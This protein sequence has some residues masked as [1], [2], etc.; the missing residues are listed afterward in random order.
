VASVSTGLDVVTDKGTVQGSTSGGVRSFLGIPY[1]ASPEG[2][3]RWKVPQPVAAWTGT[4]DATALG[5]V[6]PQPVAWPA[7]NAWRGSDGGTDDGGSETPIVTYNEASSEDC[8]SI[9]VWTPD[10]AP[11]APL[12]VMVYIHGGA[13]FFGSSTKDFGSDS[14]APIFTGQ[15]LVPKG[16]VVVVTFNYRLGQLGFLAHNALSA[17]SASGSSGNYGLLDQRA[18]LQ[19]VQTNIAAFGGDKNNVTIFGESA[20]GWSVCL[21]L[22]SPGSSGLF[23]RAIVESGICV[24]PLST[25][26][27]A[28]ARG[29]AFAKL[30]GCTDP[31][32]VLS[33]LRGLT[34]EAIATPSFPIQ[35]GGLFFQDSSTALFPAPILDGQVMTGQPSALLADKQMASVPVLVGA[36]TS[37]GLLFNLPGYFL[38]IPV[39]S[40]AEYRAALARLFDGASSSVAMQYPSSH[41]ASPNDALSQ[42]AADAVFVCEAR[43]TAQL[44]ATAGDTAYLYSF[45]GNLS[46]TPLTQLAGKAFHSAELPYVFG[47]GDELGSCPDSNQ[48]LADAIQRYW[49]RFAK[50]GDP[51]GGPDP[52]WPP[53]TQAGDEHLT[54]DTTI[55]AASGLEKANCDF[56]DTLGL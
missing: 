35:P 5:P 32:N 15:E 28:E 29:D 52:K 38:D 55:A 39:Q 50:N 31:A 7:A 41:F 43:K 40:D 24:A 23:H 37:E 2:A 3:N 56:W 17:E 19:W 4:K 22:V 18:A 14:A 25:L 12:P 44:L 53:Y 47:A 33:C 51:N 9:N 42:V 30:M 20:G 11:T 6:C 36:N 45:N 26:S 16:N 49:T 27:A 10:P 8:L 34:A 54:L 13:W 1:A 46:G 21:H 48:A